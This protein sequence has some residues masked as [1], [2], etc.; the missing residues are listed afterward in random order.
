ME[1]IRIA[2]WNANGLLHHLHEIEMFL[3]IQ[4]IDV[5]LISE[6]HFTRENYIKIRGYQVYHTVHPANKARGGT[7]VIIK[8][9]LKHHEET[10]YQTEAIQATSVKVQTKFK[11]YTLTAVY[12]PPRYILKKKTLLNFSKH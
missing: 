1:C 7:A 8:N 12:C 11:Q 2:E 3:K 4:K 5:C 10:K 9:E 6:T